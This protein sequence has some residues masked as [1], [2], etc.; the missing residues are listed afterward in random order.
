MIE[1]TKDEFNQ[2]GENCFNADVALFAFQD[3]FKYFKQGEKILD[4]K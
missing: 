3:I 4:G 2:G 1:A